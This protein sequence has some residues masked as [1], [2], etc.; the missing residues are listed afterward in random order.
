MQLEDPVKEQKKIIYEEI[1]VVSIH[2]GTEESLL[3]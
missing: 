2:D 3:T 1:Q